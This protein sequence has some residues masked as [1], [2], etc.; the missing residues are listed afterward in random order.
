M[1]RLS[2]RVALVTGALRGIGLAIATRFAREG[3]SVTLAD[4][5]PADSPEVAKVLAA[6]GAGRITGRPT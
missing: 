1:D 3:A 2:G 5:D 6:L 4:L